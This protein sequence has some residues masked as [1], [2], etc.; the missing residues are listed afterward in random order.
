MMVITESGI[1]N[2]RGGVTCCTISRYRTPSRKPIQEGLEATAVVKAI[3]AIL[4]NTDY[5]D[6]H[7]G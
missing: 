5:A 3:E 6:G 2:W 7:I 4:V 1:L